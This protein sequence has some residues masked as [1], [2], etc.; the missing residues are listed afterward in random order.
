MIKPEKKKPSNLRICLLNWINIKRKKK[1]F[2][3]KQNVFGFYLQQNESFTNKSQ[4]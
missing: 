2:T 1:T 3:I 4:N